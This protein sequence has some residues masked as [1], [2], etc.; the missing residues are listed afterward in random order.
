MWHLKT[1]VQKHLLY[2]KSEES[3][4]GNKVQ[5][6]KEQTQNI[7]LKYLMYMLHVKWYSTK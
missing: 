3:L 5:Q 7:C 6:S 2:N 1:A 4:G